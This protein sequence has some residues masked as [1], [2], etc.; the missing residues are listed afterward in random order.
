MENVIKN[1]TMS[2]AVMIEEIVVN[3][4]ILQINVNGICWVMDSVNLNV[5]IKDVNEILVIV[6][7]V[8]IKSLMD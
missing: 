6:N 8:L 5:L 3:I 7:I 4:V 1:V 2:C